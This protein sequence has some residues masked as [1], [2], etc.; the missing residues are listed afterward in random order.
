[1]RREALALAVRMA[2]LDNGGSDEAVRWFEEISTLLGGEDSGMENYSAR[3]AAIREQVT[4]FAADCLVPAP[5]RKESAML[6]YQ[7]YL[8]W[9]DATRGERLTLNLFGR[10]LGGIYSKAKGGTVWYMDVKLREDYR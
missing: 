10:A 5:G 9:W 8:R 3:H 1:M 7:G 6:I 2:G 4:T